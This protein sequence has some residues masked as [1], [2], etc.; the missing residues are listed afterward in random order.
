MQ[1]KV[2]LT[3]TWDRPGAAQRLALT[4]ALCSV[5]SAARTTDRIRAQT[6]A[7]NGTPRADLPVMICD[8][9]YCVQPL[10]A[11]GEGLIPPCHLCLHFRPK[12]RQL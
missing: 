3:K 12:S 10:E 1:S 11:W 2:P 5:Q 7:A 4:R 8:A 9:D 6:E